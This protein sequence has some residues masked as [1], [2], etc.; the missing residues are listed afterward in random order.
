MIQSEV[1]RYFSLAYPKSLVSVRALAGSYLRNKWFSE[2]WSNSDSLAQWCLFLY[3]PSLVMIQPCFAGL[4]LNLD[5]LSC[6]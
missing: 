2:E 1:Q 4:F 6:S 5:I 3:L